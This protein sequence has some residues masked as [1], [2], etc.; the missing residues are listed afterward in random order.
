M[1]RLTSLQSRSTGNGN[2]LA[3]I[4]AEK[5]ALIEKL[6]G[7]SVADSKWR[8]GGEN[9]IITLH[10]NGTSSISW[11]GRRGSWKSAGP[12]DL[13]LDIWNTPQTDKV[14]IN[15]DATEITWPDGAKATRLSQ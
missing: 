15:D 12:N 2:L 10:A 14:R 9:K 3:Q 6:K 4:E 7:P 13:V 11:S 1:Q 8:F 5:K